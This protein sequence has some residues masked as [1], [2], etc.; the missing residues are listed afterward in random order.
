MIFTRKQL[1]RFW[2]NTADMLREGRGRYNPRRGEAHGLAK[3][4]DWQVLKI[5]RLARRGLSFS[6]IAPRFGVSRELVGRIVL[7]RY[8]RHLP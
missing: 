2:A 6:K 8:W 4:V 5:R 7:H 3:L 1:R